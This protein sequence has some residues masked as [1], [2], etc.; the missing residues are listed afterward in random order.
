MTPQE[1]QAEIDRLVAQHGLQPI[2]LVVN[3]RLTRTGGLAVYAKGE[4]QMPGWMLGCAEAGNTVRHEVAHYLAHARHSK[5]IA[6]HGREWRQAAIDCGAI[7]TPYVGE[8]AAAAA[9]PARR[10]ERQWVG[11]CGQGCEFRRVRA[12]AAMREEQWLC[13]QHRLSLIWRRVEGEDQ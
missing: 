4:I 2:R 8:V 12:T 9:P 11:T 3:N 1:A 13:N 10:L 6:P 7:P 5:R